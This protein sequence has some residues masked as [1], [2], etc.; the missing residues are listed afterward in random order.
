MHVTNICQTRLHPIQLNTFEE[1]MNRKLSYIVIW[2]LV[3]LNTN[4]DL[5]LSMKRLLSSKGTITQNS[6]KSCLTLPCWYSLDDS[7]CVLSDEYPFA[8][9]SVIFQLFPHQFLMTKLATRSTKVDMNLLLQPTYQ[10]NRNKRYVIEHL[11][12]N[13][14]IPIIGMCYRRKRPPKL[15][16]QVRF[17]GS[18]YYWPLPKPSVLIGLK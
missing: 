17:S 11:P 8:I 10:V 9:V 2:T 5:I 7:C 4:I 15:T 16:R 12:L 18:K 14:L 6:L 13:D 3:R 1:K